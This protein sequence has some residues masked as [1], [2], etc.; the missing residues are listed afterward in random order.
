MGLT[1]LND[2]KEGDR[3]YIATFEGKQVG[4][5]A[6]ALWPA[7]QLAVQYFK[8]AKRKMGLLSVE[9]AEG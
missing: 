7:K 4:F 9:L 2:K 5:Y 1:I 6:P 8:P 3:A